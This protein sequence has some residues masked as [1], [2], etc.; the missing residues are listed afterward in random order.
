M[1]AL[2]KDRARRYETANGLARDLDRYMNDEPVSAYPPT[3]AYRLQKFVRR[4]RTAL[5]IA[6]SAFA[7]L[8][9]LV[10]ILTVS[11][12]RVAHE[13]NEKAIALTERERA[14]AAAKASAE[15]AEAQRQRAERNFYNA[16]VAV[17]AILAQAATGQGDWATL[18][19][20][21]RKTFSEATAQYY[22]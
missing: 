15:R 9:A 3:T 22:H 10:A 1:K 16:R 2:E 12:V 18:S 13:R 8:I 17:M 14:L 21:L 6:T 7:A 19:P 20:A 4:N 5:L 11:N